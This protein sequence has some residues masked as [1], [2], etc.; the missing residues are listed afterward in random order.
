VGTHNGWPPQPSSLPPQIPTLNPTPSPPNPASGLKALAQAL[1]ARHL[2][3]NMQLVL[4]ARV[5]II[6]F[7][8]IDSGLAFDVSWE[9]SRQG[10]RVITSHPPTR[11]P[12]GLAGGS[13]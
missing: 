5:P 6:K 8:M 3:R 7:E 11:P 2:V 1:E 10:T 12:A 13:Q 9:V 4:S